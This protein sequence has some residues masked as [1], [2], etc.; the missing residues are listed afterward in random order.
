MQF[1]GGGPI[2]RCSR[3]EKKKRHRHP[4]QYTVFGKYANRKEAPMTRAHLTLDE[5]GGIQALFALGLSRA[6]IARQTGRNRSTIGRELARNGVPAR[7]YDPDKAQDRYVEA[8]RECVKPRSL[9]HPPLRRYLFE[10]GGDAWSPEQVSGRLRLEF[11]HDPRMHVSPETI[12]RTLYSDERFGR[13]LIPQLRQG[14]KRRR[15]RGQGLHRRGPSIPN[16]VSIEKRPEEVLLMRQYGHWEG[17][18]IL[19]KNQRGAAVT[20]VERKS[21]FLRAVVVPSKHAGPVARAVVR[22]LGDL[23][24]HCV[25]TITLDNGT[26]FAD[27]GDVARELGTN[28]YFAHPYS[29]NER[30]RNENTNGLLRQYLPKGSSFEN[31]SQHQLDAIVDELNNRPRK[32]LGYRTPREVFEK[33]C[34]AVEM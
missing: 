15:K 14:R 24:A 2:R 4:F 22:A 34:V 6:E 29:S 27:H 1:V 17:D 21:L 33:A 26:E 12:Y 25:R 19:G 3:E 18:T 8:R 13:V 31:L 28:V 7:A 16:R 20:L 23:P 30:A 32:S 5:R 9:D 11:P 10:K